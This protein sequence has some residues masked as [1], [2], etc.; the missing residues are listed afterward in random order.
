MFAP[1]LCFLFARR[2]IF[3]RAKESGSITSVPVGNY[4]LRFQLGSDRPSEWRFCQVMGT[5]EFDEAIDFHDIKS[6][7]RTN[8][9]AY[10]VTL[11]P[12]L[13]G[14]ATTHQVSNSVFELPER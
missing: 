10:E 5:S 4:R 13:S 11:Q 12:V 9:S 3:I 8:Y 2:A 6:E 14:T 7:R 1:R